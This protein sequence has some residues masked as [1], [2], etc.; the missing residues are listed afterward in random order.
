MIKKTLSYLVDSRCMERG[1]A[2]ELLAESFLTVKAA[3]KC[4]TDLQLR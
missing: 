4:E 3:S 1:K 2:D